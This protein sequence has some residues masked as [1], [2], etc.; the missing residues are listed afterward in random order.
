MTSV[1][2]DLL[3]DRD[4]EIIKAYFGLGDSGPMGTDTI[5]ERFEMTTVR[6]SQIV[7]AS[8]EKMKQNF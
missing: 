7:K 2:V 5:A 6:V 4:Q 3:K 1:D 8:L